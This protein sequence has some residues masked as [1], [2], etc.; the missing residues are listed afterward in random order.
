[1]DALKAE[2]NFWRDKARDLQLEKKDVKAELANIVD[3]VDDV[4]SAIEAVM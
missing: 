2:R 4:A 1:M 3:D